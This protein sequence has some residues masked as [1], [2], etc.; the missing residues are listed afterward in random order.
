MGGRRG[1]RQIGH[2]QFPSK[3]HEP[4]RKKSLPAPAPVDECTDDNAV[5]GVRFDGKHL[6]RGTL[7]EHI[8]HPADIQRA[9]P[10]R[11]NAPK[12][13]ITT[14]QASSLKKTTTTDKHIRDLICHIFGQNVAESIRKE[15]F[16][17]DF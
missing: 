13:I 7:Y 16:E 12:H 1:G 10:N 5:R 8:R 2:P 9:G 4:S 6:Y 15:G 17:H 11:N 14:C 3:A